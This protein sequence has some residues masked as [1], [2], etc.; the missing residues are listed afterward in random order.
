MD[1]GDD[2]LTCTG[3][4]NN[5]L[6]LHTITQ[7]PGELISSRNILKQFFASNRR[8]KAVAGANQRPLL[9]IASLRMLG[10][11]HP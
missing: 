5:D 3:S 10:F 7:L 4:T 1:D 6:S 9:I 2:F 8:D 11:V